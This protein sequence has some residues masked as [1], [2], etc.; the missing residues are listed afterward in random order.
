MKFLA[1]KIAIWV[2]KMHSS[3]ENMPLFGFVHPDVIQAGQTGIVPRPFQRDFHAVAQGSI[4]IQA[5]HAV[6]VLALSKAASSISRPTMPTAT[7]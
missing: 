1:Q 7:I 3:P 2:K 5:H 4:Q 6:E